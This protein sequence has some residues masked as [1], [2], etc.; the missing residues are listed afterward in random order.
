MKAGWAIL[1]AALALVPAVALGGGDQIGYVKMLSG[2][3][4]V[5]SVDDRVSRPLRVA[6][7]IHEGDRVETGRDGQI[8]ITFSDNTRITLGP[9]S[10]VVIV[11]F[12]F[13]PAE[14]KYGFVLRLIYGTLQYL[15]GLTEKL[16]PETM[17]IE[18]PGST[19]AVRGTRLLIRAEKGP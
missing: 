1:M 18:T 17:S 19:V 6:A 14:R 16:A 7:P 4:S 3:A 12:V 8:G 9:E 5:V 10:S 15:S 2:A 13:V 11:R